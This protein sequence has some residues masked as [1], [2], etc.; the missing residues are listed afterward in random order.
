[1]NKTPNQLL[2]IF[3]AS[4][5]LTERKLIPALF[6]LFQGGHLPPNFAVL[7][8][9]RTSGDDTSFRERVVL[10]NKYIPETIRNHGLRKDFANRI[11][12]WTLEDS[13]D[14][15]YSGLKDRI[16]A[17]DEQEET[18]GNHI[19]YAKADLML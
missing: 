9:S 10:K 17:L 8:I 1:M 18:G 2:V 16:D 3:G 7:G 15:D 13:Y 4:G 14:T 5:D 11:F 19:F 12:Y 6:D